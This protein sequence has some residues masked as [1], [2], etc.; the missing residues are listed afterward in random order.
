MKINILGLLLFLFY[1]GNNFSANGQ[2]DSIVAAKTPSVLI[3]PYSRMMHLSDAD[4]DIANGSD[5]EIPKMREIF[6]K[7]LIKSLNEKFAYT[8]DLNE[9]QHD[10]V[11]SEEP[12]SDAIYHSLLYEQDSI[13][14]LK[15]PS[16][17]AVKDSLRPKDVKLSKNESKYINVQV[18]DQYLVSDLSKQY[19][20]DYIIFLNEFDIKTHSDDCINLALQIYRRDLKVH[21]SIFDKTGKQ[22]YGDVAVAYFDSNSNDVKDISQKNFPAISD[23]ILKSFEKATK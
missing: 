18:N 2:S 8:S 4:I 19:K 6:R 15:N 12:G 16:R 14:P 11:K 5:M 1:F 22:V 10:F 9:S 3:V 21:Y 17:F 13:Y 20:A 7:E 23:Y